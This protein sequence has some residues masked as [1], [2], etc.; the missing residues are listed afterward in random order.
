M[1]VANASSWLLPTPVHDCCQR[2]F[3]IIDDA[4]LWLLQTP[5][6]NDRWRRVINCWWRRVNNCWWRRVIIVCRHRV[7]LVSSTQ[8]NWKIFLPYI[9][10]TCSPQ[11]LNRTKWWFE[12]CFHI[13]TA[14]LKKSMLFISVT[15][16]NWI[17][18]KCSPQV[19]GC[20]ACSNLGLEIALCS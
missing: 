4:R 8:K 5:G 20:H 9:H 14:I 15:S 2:R 13:I 10:I 6:H 1:I 11:V 12:T 16:K 3:M 7:N 19:P 17:K 18:K